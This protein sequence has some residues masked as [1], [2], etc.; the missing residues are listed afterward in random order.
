[1][2]TYAAW[3]ILKFV[4]LALLTTGCVGPAFVRTR[5]DRGNLYSVAVVGWLLTWIAGYGLLKTLGMK[6]SVDWVTLGLVWSAIAVSASLASIERPAAAGIGAGALVAGLIPMVQ[7]SVDPTWMLVALVPAVL[8]GA[9]GWRQASEGPAPSS[10]GWFRTIAWAEGLSLILLFGLYMPAKRIWH[11]ELDGG[12]GWFG[13]VHGML[14]VIYVV[15]LGRWVLE[16]W[17]T[18]GSRARA[19][20]IGFVASLLPF[21]TVLFERHAA[22]PSAP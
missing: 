1:M 4:G 8:V 14:F 22:P 20:C 12:Q 15:A 2:T 9:Q 5:V 13:W 21:G 6:L 17:D 10:W 11:I 19:F 16:R 3:R 7:R 18:G